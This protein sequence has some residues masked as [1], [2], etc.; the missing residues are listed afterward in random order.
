MMDALAPAKTPA[1]SGNRK[2]PYADFHDVLNQANCF[3]QPLVGSP[4][5]LLEGS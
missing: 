2:L 1:Y 4:H 3:K 5:L